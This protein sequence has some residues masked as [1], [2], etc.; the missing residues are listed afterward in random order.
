MMS[1]QMPAPDADDAAT[2]AAREIGQVISAFRAEVLDKIRT[3]VEAEI[4][5][6]EEEGFDPA[7]GRGRSRQLWAKGG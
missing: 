2:A 4:E 5:K 1:E 3:D 6:M 7:M